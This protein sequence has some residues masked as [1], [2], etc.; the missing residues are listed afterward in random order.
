[1]SVRKTILLSLLTL[2]TF[3]C[4]IKAQKV[5]GIVVDAQSGQGCHT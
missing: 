3:T 4:N 1:M 2:L 5:S